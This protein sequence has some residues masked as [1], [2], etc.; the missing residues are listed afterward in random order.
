MFTGPCNTT[1]NNQISSYIGSHT[2]HTAKAL[3]KDAFHMQKNA[4]RSILVRL[5]IDVL[6]TS[7]I[8][9]QYS[10]QHGKPVLLF[11][12]VDRYLLKAFGLE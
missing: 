12:A 3:C 10:L 2:C 9:K 6:D 11:G 5:D 1:F 8:G 4:W 7:C